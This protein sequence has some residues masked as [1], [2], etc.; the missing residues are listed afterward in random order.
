MTM[1]DRTVNTLSVLVVDDSPEIREYLETLLQAEGYRVT[2]A[3]NGREALTALEQTPVPPVGQDARRPA[4][5]AYHAARRHPLRARGDAGAPRRRGPRG[6][7]GGS[8]LHGRTI[9]GRRAR[10]PAARDGG[11]FPLGDDPVPC[12]L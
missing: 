12:R 11:A 1:I 6:L 7:A 3:G 5:G 10:R 8:A 4:A 9:R 2:T